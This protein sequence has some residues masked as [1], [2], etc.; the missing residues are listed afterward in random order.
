METK[1]IT[2]ASSEVLTGY[3]HEKGRGRNDSQHLRAED[4]HHDRDN[5]GDEVSGEGHVVRLD[6]AVFHGRRKRGRKTKSVKLTENIVE[7]EKLTEGYARNVEMAFKKS[8]SPQ[9][10]SRGR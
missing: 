2:S 4:S 1:N 8:P 6:E 7:T 3:R 9:R 5:S 10:P